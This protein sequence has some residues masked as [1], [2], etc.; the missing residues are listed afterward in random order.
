MRAI[1]VLSLL[2]LAALVV[3]CG[4]APAESEGEAPAA[5]ESAASDIRTEEVT[6]QVGDESFTG[7][8][9]YDGSTDEARPGVI[10]VHEWWGHN[11]YARDRAEQLAGMGYTALALDMF[12]SGKLADHP[13]DAGAF[14]SAV[15]ADIDGAELRFNTALDLLKNHAT[16]DAEKVAAIGYCFGG[17]VVLHMARVGTDLDAVASF[18]GMLGAAKTAEP[19]SIK[20]RVLVYNG[21]DDPMISADAV[22]AFEEEMDT[23]GATYEVKNYAGAKH[24]FTNPGATAVGEKFE[25]PLA[26]DEAADKDSWASMAAAFAEVF[27]S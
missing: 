13:D 22:A 15:F 5:A 8:F 27:G 9:A 1:H 18:H 21:A 20:A 14:A 16:V 25:M 23:A 6:Y 4:G 26:Y 2:F 24:S 11:D 3:A 17:G 12:G 7:Y 10:V 19:G